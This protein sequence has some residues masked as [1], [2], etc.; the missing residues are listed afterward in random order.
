MTITK[1]QYRVL[2][3]CDCPTGILAEHMSGSEKRTAQTLAARD[4]LFLEAGKRA[5]LTDKGR[6]ALDGALIAD[7]NSWYSAVQQEDNARGAR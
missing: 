1:A 7:A 2:Q 3:L 5:R 4:L 6:A